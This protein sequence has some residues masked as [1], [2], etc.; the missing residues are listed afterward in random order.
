MIYEYRCKK[1]EHE[2]EAF[3]KM[4]DPELKKC[5]SCKKVS[6]VKLISGGCYAKVKQE[7][8]TLGSLAE[9]NSKKLGKYGVE[10]RARKDGVWREPKPEP[11]FGSM[12]ESKVK[13]IAK[14][15]NPNER[16]KI[17]KNYIEKGN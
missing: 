4:S 7:P 8:T 5:P 15:T 10:D 16:A 17:V 3:Q 6:L 9:A 1:C 2:F 14:T 11:F 12:P 13:E